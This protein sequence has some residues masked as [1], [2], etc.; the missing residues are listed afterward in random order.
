MDDVR[1]K[2]PVRPVRLIDQIRQEIRN[3]NLSYATERTYVGWILRFIRFHGRKHP[4]QMGSEQVE[5]FLNHLSVHKNCSVN[6]QKVALNALVFL[7]REFLKIELT[8]K[9]KT[10][11]TVTRVPVVFS[12]SEALAVISNLSGVHQL[13]ARLLYGSGLRINECLRLRVKDIDFEM[14]H[15]IVRNGKGYKDRVTIL[16]DAIKQNLTLQIEFVKSLHE[17][18]LDKGCGAVYLPNALNRKYPQAAESIGWQYCFPARDTSMDPRSG[19]ERR[20][21]ILA[22]SVQRQVKTAIKSSGIKKQSSSHTFRH[23]FATRLLEAGYDLRTIQ[24]YLGH[25]DVRTTEI[26]THVIK[27][28][29]RPVISPIDELVREPPAIYKLA[30]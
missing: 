11:K 20:H 27:Q 4:E 2:L 5:E 22:Q 17:L 29:Q 23:S 10:A 13:V 21:H 18:D 28:L 7:F 9:Y 16:P 3:R 1:A 6:T 25:S 12:H 14:N 15:I 30:S 26:Y 24:E 8:L 19:T